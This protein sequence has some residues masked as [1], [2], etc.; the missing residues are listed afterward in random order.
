[1]K[2]YLLP[3]MVSAAL[4]GGCSAAYKTGQTPDD[5]YY[6]SGP[7][8]RDEAPRTVTNS[9]EEYASYWG[10]PEDDYLRMK[11]RNPNRWGEIDNFNYWNN[12][13][14]MSMMGAFNNPCC[15]NTGF[16]NNG[17]G[18][19]N[20]FNNFNNWNSGW[21]YNAWNSGWGFGGLGFNN[22]GNNYWN[23]PVVY[24][25]G[26]DYNANRNT[27]RP[28]S[29][30][31]FRGTQFDRGSSSGNMFKSNSNTSSNGALFRSIFSGS[32]NS[33]NNSGSGTL[34][35]AARSFGTGSGSS[36]GGSSSGG[37]SRSSG[38]GSSSGSSS[39]GGRGGRGG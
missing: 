22:W 10:N 23:R 4:L 15:C 12:F 24:Y 8:V 32:N 33:S 38:G 17:F 31:V 11:V 18:G 28:S 14:S 29:L 39:S 36:S 16:W 6:S 26:K 19:F 1:M 5:V 7:V 3:L 27:F 34:E 35:K 9:N 25:P 21:N 20:H 30:G 2:N 13:N 37:S